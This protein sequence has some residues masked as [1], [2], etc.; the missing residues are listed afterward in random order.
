MADGAS[1]P[2][3]ADFLARRPTGE[4]DLIQVCAD[5]RGEVAGE[6]E[7][8]SLEEAGRLYPT[9]AKRLLTLTHDAAAVRAPAGTDVR[10]AYDW[11]RTAQGEG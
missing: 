9:A 8:R 6:G 5:P 7:V 4:A 1:H 10:P 3:H 11:M 2:L